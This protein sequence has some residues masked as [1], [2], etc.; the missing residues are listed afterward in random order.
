MDY[1][2][3]LVLL[4][5][6]LLQVTVCHHQT[7]AEDAGGVS[8]GDLPGASSANLTDKAGINSTDSSVH[9]N[10]TIEAN[11]NT[12]DTGIL[13]KVKHSLESFACTIG[14]SSECHAAEG[15]EKAGETKKEETKVEGR[16]D[17]SSNNSTTSNTTTP[18]SS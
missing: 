6:S 4:T 14:L 7:R 2:T 10:K 1:K 13:S 16:S 8:K 11:G 17:I 12:T 15:D 18:A 5:L 9:L 3:A